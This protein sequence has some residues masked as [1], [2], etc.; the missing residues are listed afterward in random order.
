[1]P[2]PPSIAECHYIFFKTEMRLVSGIRVADGSLGGFSDFFSV[3]IYH[4]NN[5]LNFLC[6]G[7]EDGVE[8]DS[9]YL[10]I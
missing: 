2:I 7:A 4:S 10:A 1:M 6:Q 5:Q 3:G 8:S 9:V